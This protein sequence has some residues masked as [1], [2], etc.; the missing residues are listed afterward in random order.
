M[1]DF[2]G[3]VASLRKRLGE[4]ERVLDLVG[5]RARLGELEVRAAEPGLWEEPETARAVTTEMARLKDDVDLLERLDG[6]LADVEALDELAR[7]EGDDSLAP[8]LDQAV[9]VLAHEL[10]DLELRSLFSGEHDDRDAV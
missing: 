9:S 8:E 7:E 3:E 5:K 6:Q 10:D 2:S 1:R 4:L